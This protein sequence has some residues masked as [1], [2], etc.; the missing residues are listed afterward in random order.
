MMRTIMSAAV[1][2]IVFLP[3]TADAGQSANAKASE[4]QWAIADKCNRNAIAKYPD[5]T[6]EALA[7]REQDVRRCNVA[8]RFQA[9][10]P[11]TPAQPSQN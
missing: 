4:T 1:V 11:L 7:K 10:T 2:V 3:V 8:N 9:R 5:H 6:S